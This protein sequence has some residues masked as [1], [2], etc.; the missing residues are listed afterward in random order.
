MLLTILLTLFVAMYNQM[1]GLL[2]YDEMDSEM[3]SET[4]FSLG[5]ILTEETAVLNEGCTVYRLTVW[6][7]ATH[8]H[9]TG[10]DVRFGAV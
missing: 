10:N 3:D 9:M 2:G 5:G 1:F 8:M 7:L 6:E 4:F